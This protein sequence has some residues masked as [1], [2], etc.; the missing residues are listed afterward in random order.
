[1]T[2]TKQKEEKCIL[3]NELMGHTSIP[4]FPQRNKTVKK[5]IAKKKK[6]VMRG[7][8]NVTVLEV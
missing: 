6:T 7:R 2:K 3:F 1:M 5:K 8:K 4:T